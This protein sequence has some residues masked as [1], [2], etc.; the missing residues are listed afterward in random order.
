MKISKEEFIMNRE[1]TNLLG[2][3][4]AFKNTITKLKFYF[5]D[6]DECL[7]YKEF[8]QEYTIIENFLK[9]I[10]NYSNPLLKN[11]KPNSFFTTIYS[12]KVQAQTKR[13]MGKIP[14]VFLFQL[15]DHLK[16]FEVELNTLNNNYKTKQPFSLFFTCFS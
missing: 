4:E 16:T 15:Q 9:D 2:K 5:K 1:S 6:K 13:K 10:L 12:Y 7:L 8:I 11:Q 3:Y 14:K